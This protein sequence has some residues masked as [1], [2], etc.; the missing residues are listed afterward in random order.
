[1]DLGSGTGK[2]EA[3]A[4][5]KSRQFTETFITERNL[6]PQLYPDLWDSKAQ[7]WIDPE[8]VPTMGG[9]YQRF[10]QKI[11]SVS[12][13]NDTGLVTL[14]ILWRDPKQAADWANDL[15]R[16]LNQRTRDRA[17]KQSQDSLDY[18]NEQ[19]NKTDIMEIRTAVFGLIEHHIN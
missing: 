5:L 3:I 12:T 19:L 6:L 15:V 16:R 18:L 11:R 7:R 1:I 4:V 13:D 17:V 8:K 10:D 9:A 14:E 2:D